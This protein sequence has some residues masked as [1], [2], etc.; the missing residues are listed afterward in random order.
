[1]PSPIGLLICYAR[2]D[3]EH[4]EKLEK[5]LELLKRRKI[6]NEIWWDNKILPGDYWDQE[7][8]GR[9]NSCQIVLILMSAETFSSTYITRVEIEIALQRKSDGLAAV[10]PVYLRYC[11]WKDDIL[12]ALQVLPSGE[13]PVIAWEVAQRDEPWMIVARGVRD[14][15]R[16]QFGVIGARPQP[17]GRTRT[18]DDTGYS[19]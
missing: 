1:M 4:C 5:H 10:I 16:E 19:I 14:V 3:R 17:K 13:R 6:L 12:G 7:I 2:Q 11:D 15:A 9:I 18:D 8:H